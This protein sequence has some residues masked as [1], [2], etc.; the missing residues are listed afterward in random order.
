MFSL[1]TQQR[2]S[3]ELGHW[4]R[5]LPLSCLDSII[6]RTSF[7]MPAID[8]NIKNSNG[9]MR[10]NGHL[11]GYISGVVDAD[12]DGILHGQMNVS[13]STETKLEEIEGGNEN[14]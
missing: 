10:V 9:T 1:A 3:R 5:V 8:L 2:A 7:K 13:V 6:E 11:R 14:A 4:T 12:F